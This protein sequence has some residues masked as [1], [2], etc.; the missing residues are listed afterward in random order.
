MHDRW[1]LEYFWDV[2]TA[3][4]ILNCISNDLKFVKSYLI[5]TKFSGDVGNSTDYIAVEAC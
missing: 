5:A 3:V 1:D 2:D 4:E